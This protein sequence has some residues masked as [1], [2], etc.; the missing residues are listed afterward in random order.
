MA[1]S[2]GSFDYVHSCPDTAESTPVKHSEPPLSPQEHSSPL[3]KKRPPRHVVYDPDLHEKREKAKELEWKL[4]LQAF[5]E[6][7]NEGVVID[8][9]IPDFKT[10]LHGR[11]SRIARSIDLPV[12]D[13]VEDLC[14]T[15][16]TT[17][18]IA[19]LLGTYCDDPKL[20]LEYA[21]EL[22]REISCSF[23]E[24]YVSLQAHV[25]N[26][27]DFIQESAKYPD[28]LIECRMKVI[29]IMLRAALRNPAYKL[30]CCDEGNP[31]V[32]VLHALAM[33][34]YIK[35]ETL[36]A[37]MQFGQAVYEKSSIHRIHSL[38]NI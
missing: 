33:S 36:P 38:G 5:L 35:S 15:A 26:L 3:R 4:S 8:D 1:S 29:L 24:D 6:V 11:I 37:Y 18:S 19:I 23:K 2:I 16:H 7:S 14:N 28:G 25:V 9:E 10:A 34:S 20:T 17:E 13:L 30:L 22:Y 27:L 32:R 12:D 21:G 31:C